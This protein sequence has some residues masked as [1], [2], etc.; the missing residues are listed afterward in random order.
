[1]DM[2]YLFLSLDW[3]GE[4]EYMAFTAYSIEN[5]HSHITASTHGTDSAPTDQ[6][7]RSEK[8]KCGRTSL[9]HT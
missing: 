3:E 8:A 7:H 9:V 6:T 1:M 2:S 5:Q 4:D